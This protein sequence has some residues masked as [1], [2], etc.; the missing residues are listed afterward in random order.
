MVVK[1]DALLRRV[2]I[3]KKEKKNKKGLKKKNG[4]IIDAKYIGDETGITFTINNNGQIKYTSTNQASWVST[5]IK[6]R[7]LTTTY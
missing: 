4:W 3:K 7:A 5:T 2:N 1:K 6:F